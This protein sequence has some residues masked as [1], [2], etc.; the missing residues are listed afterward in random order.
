ME[1]EARRVGGKTDCRKLIDLLARRAAALELLNEAEQE[2]NEALEDADP[3]MR[4]AFL[5]CCQRQYS[6][7]PRIEGLCR[8]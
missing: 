4:Q 7:I 1:S 8:N 6:G 2:L 3:Q 5:G